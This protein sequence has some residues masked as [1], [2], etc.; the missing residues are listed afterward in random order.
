V[1]YA[2]LR[3]PSRQL[4]SARKSTASYHVISI[5]NQCKG[6]GTNSQLTHNNQKR[7][8]YTKTHKN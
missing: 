7:I 3:W 1:P 8:K 6:I 2:R 5:D 4:L